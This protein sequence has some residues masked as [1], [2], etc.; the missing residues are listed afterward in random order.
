[1]GGASLLEAPVVAI[2]NT[3]APE[4][5]PKWSGNTRGQAKHSKLSCPPQ[6]VPPVRPCWRLRPRLWTHLRLAGFAGDLRVFDGGSFESE[7]SSCLG[8]GTRDGGVGDHGRYGYLARGGYREGLL[9]RRGMESR[10]GHRRVDE[11]ESSADDRGP[12]RLNG[13]RWGGLVSTTVTRRPPCWAAGLVVE[14]RA[15][16]PNTLVRPKE[17]KATLKARR[18]EPLDMC[19]RVDWGEATRTNS[20]IGHGIGEARGFSDTRHHGEGSRDRTR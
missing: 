10:G 20:L 2:S 13:S 7:S 18:R 19:V 12:S 4:H 15:L 16:S 5:M 11:T 17:G 1:M 3:K 6:P 8:V 9:A 14:L